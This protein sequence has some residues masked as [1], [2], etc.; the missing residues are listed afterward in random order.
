MNLKLKSTL[1]VIIELGAVVLLFTLTVRAA[2]A[3]ASFSSSEIT[4]S[5]WGISNTFVTGGGSISTPL[6]SGDNY[7]HKAHTSGYARN[8]DGSTTPI[9]VRAQARS[10]ELSDVHST[11]CQDRYSSQVTAYGEVDAYTSYA[12]S[13]P[14]GG[15]PS[16]WHYYYG[17]GY[18]WVGTY[19]GETDRQS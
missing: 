5:T 13:N 14:C 9:Q 17:R 7:R 16:G 2:V 12:S 1:F 10:Y 11:P 18:H 3:A 6:W 19:Y 4:A 8:S 15:S